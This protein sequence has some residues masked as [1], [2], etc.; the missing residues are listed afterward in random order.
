M[1]ARVGQ[2]VLREACR[3]LRLSGVG[4]SV[5]RWLAIG[6]LIVG[7]GDTMAA[8]FYPIGRSVTGGIILAFANRTCIEALTAP[9]MSYYSVILHLTFLR[10][11]HNE[12]KGDTLKDER[13]LLHI[14][15]RISGHIE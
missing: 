10:S 3:G 4:M 8:G 5:E 15:I 9:R 6:L 14:R 13:L 11:I 1:G 7:I 2:L 12:R